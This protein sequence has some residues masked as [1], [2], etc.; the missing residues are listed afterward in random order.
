MARLS[1]M[2]EE[3]LA[4]FAK[5]YQA[6]KSR[7]E[8]AHRCNLQPVEVTQIATQLRNAGVP[9]KSFPRGRTK[10]LTTAKVQ[11]IIAALNAK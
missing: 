1:D 9:L 8:V 10:V 5:T 2:S 7:Q 11:G 4:S 3:K 6:S